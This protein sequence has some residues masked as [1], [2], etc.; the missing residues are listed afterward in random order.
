MMASPPLDESR[1]PVRYEAWLLNA[2][3]SFLNVSRE[4][5]T[6]GMC[7]IMGF[8]NITGSH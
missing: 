2:C 1:L 4:G 5:A 6:T 3:G 7:K 8:E